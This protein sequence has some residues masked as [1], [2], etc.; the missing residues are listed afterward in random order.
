MNW[1]TMNIIS[2]TT[3]DDGN[4]ET[5]VATQRPSMKRWRIWSTSE[6]WF[7]ISLDDNVMFQHPATNGVV[8]NL[9]ASCVVFWIWLAIK[10]LQFVVDQICNRKYILFSPSDL[11]SMSCRISDVDGVCSGFCISTPQIPRSRAR[12]SPMCVGL[13]CNLSLIHV[14]HTADE[15]FPWHY[16]KHFY[17]SSFFA[18]LYFCVCSWT[19]IA[20]NRRTNNK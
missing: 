6:Q 3:S 14:I 17:S 4:H 1:Q 19:L 13:F 16:P 12:G 2:P 10:S 5:A 7:N 15:D 18:F 9:A 11:D 20:T 8:H